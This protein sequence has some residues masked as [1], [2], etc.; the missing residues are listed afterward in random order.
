MLSGEALLIISAKATGGAA[1]SK[2]E[3]LVELV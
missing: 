2:I 3:Q 1:G